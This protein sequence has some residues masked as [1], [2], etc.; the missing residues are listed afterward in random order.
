MIRWPRTFHDLRGSFITRRCAAG[1]TAEEVALCRGHKMSGE[2]G[3]QSAYVDRAAIALANAQRL[4]E[5]HYGTVIEQ[6]LQ[7]GLQTAVGKDGLSA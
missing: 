7:T 4:A 1:G 5:R 3:A 6:K 2:Q